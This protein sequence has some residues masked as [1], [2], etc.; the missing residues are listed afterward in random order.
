VVGG[1]SK[2]VHLPLPAD[3]PKQR[4]PDITLAEKHLKWAPTV[5]LAEGLKRTADYFRT[6]I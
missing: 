3:D 6:Q 4:R 5:S 1:A 2:I